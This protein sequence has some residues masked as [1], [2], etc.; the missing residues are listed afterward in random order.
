MAGLIELLYDADFYGWTQVQAKLLR[1]RR[2]RLVDLEHL[3]EEIESLG[4][5][6]RRE[7]VSRLAILLGHL[8]KWQH[9]PQRQSNVW[10][11]TIREQRRK[12]S[13]LIQQ[14]PSLGPNLPE[15]L[16]EAYE[17]GIDLAVQETDLPYQTFPDA[18]PYS[19]EQILAAEFLPDQL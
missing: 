3:I 4:R 18:C 9:Q 17:D 12:V 11:A 15:I 7:L 14:N 19:L 2:W 1:E 8:L 13:R 10:L 6:E 16:Q 5:Q